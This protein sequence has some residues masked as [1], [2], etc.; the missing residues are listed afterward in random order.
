MKDYK[1]YIITQDGMSGL[2]FEDIE[3]HLLT[4]SDY[5]RFTEWMKGQTCG[6]LGN[7]IPVVYPYDYDKFIRGMKVTD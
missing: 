1:K 5:K 7:R 3:Q 2:M 4:P 6:L